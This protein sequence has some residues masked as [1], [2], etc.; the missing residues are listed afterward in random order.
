MLA[1][2]ATIGQVAGLRMACILFAEK[3]R[4]MLVL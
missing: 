4:M 1:E 2:K 3:L